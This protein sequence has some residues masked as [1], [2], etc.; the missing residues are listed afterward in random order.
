MKKPFHIIMR[1][2]RIAAIL[3]TIFFAWLTW[4]MWVFFKGHFT[5]MKEWV[6]VGFVSMNALAAGAVKW[7]MENFMKRIEKDDPVDD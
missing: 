3:I 7:A 4:D 6:M 5:E 2:Y 1:Q